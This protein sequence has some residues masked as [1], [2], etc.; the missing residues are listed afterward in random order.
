MCLKNDSQQN[1]D[2]GLLEHKSISD[3]VSIKPY[4]EF[5]TSP[6]I[7]PGQTV[8]LPFFMTFDKGLDSNIVENVGLTIKISRKYSRTSGDIKR[9]IFEQIYKFNL[10]REQAENY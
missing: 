7:G 4:S 1:F 9:P 10:Y 2:Q 5:W 6:T 3:K 8:Q